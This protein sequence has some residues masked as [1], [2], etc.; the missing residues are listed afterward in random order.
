M[1]FLKNNK[2]TKFSLMKILMLILFISTKLILSQ[3]IT[4][5]RQFGDLSSASSFDIDLNHNIYVTDIVDN[6]LT[7]YDSTGIEQISIGGS[8][9]EESTFDEPVN[10]FTNT[11]SVYVADKNNNRIQRF[12]KDLNFLS[13]FKGDDEETE[14][15]F[16]YPICVGISNI[17][18]LF[19]LETDNNKILKFNLNGDF[20]LEIGGNDAGDFAL[21]NPISF[22]PDPNS[23]LFVLDGNLI[24]VFDQYGNRK[25]NYKIEYHP[26]K[27]RIIENDILYIENQKLTLYD[28]KERKLKSE[29]YKF[30]NISNHEIIDAVI[31][32]NLLY[33]LTANFIQIYY[34]EN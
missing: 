18:D 7:K 26:K 13:Q 22:S 15:E 28:L 6:T 2:L 9:W 23:N 20:L 12:D 3:N 33:I 5:K 14:T 32:N 30:Q 4:L 31:V 29:F 27:I 21:I 11:L 34:I 10:V 24:K 25:L 16:G 17:G 8:G 1:I 19:L